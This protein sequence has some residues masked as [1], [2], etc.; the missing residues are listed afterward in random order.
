MDVSDNH[1]C[2]RTVC[3]H[4]MTIPSGLA[5]Y[6]ATIAAQQQRIARLERVLRDCRD[7]LKPRVVLPDG[8]KLVALVE[9]TLEGSNE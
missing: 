6:A 4:R 1:N 3:G 9:R 2:L 8:F 5:A 7:Y